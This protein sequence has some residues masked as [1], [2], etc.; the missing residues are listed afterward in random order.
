MINLESLGLSELQNALTLV[1]SQIATYQILYT[2]AKTQYNNCMSMIFDAKSKLSAAQNQLTSAV[3]NVSGVQ[4]ESVL[5]SDLLEVPSTSPEVATASV[6][7]AGL[8]VAKKNAEEKVNKFQEKINKL[9]EWQTK[10]ELKIQKL[11]T[12]AEQLKADATDLAVKKSSQ[13]L[14]TVTN[15]KDQLITK[16]TTGA[17]NNVETII[18]KAKK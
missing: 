6:E 13:L 10:I 1:K 12:K 9:K 14:N 5:P 11:Q 15:K 7:T 8:Q 4:V 3:K 17:T 2:T 18:T 16:V